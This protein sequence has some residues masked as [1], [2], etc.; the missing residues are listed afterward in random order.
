MP[1]HEQD[2]KHD[3][4]NDHDGSEADIH[5]VLLSRLQGSSRGCLIG[6]SPAGRA[7]GYFL[8]A[9]LTFSP[10][11][12]RSP[13]AWSPWPSASSDSLLAAGSVPFGAVPHSTLLT[14]YTCS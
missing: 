7:L 4:H 11:C 12:L 6:L 14:L 5:G 13:L 2:K 8:K 9:S 10:A 1:A 3:D